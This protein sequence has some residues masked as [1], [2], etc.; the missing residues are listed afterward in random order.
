MAKLENLAEAVGKEEWKKA[1]QD[2]TKFV[3]WVKTTF[4]DIESYL[5]FIDAI[6]GTIEKNVETYPPE[7]LENH[8]EILRRLLVA[9]RSRTRAFV[10]GRKALEN[11][12]RM[13]TAKAS[14]DENIQMLESHQPEAALLSEPR[15]IPFSSGI[16]D[17]LFDRAE[18]LDAPFQVVKN[19]AQELKRI[20]DGWDVLLLVIDN[21]PP[22]V[23]QARNFLDL[24]D[25]HAEVLGQTRNNLTFDWISGIYPTITNSDE[26][27]KHLVATLQ[28][29]IRRAEAV[30]TAGEVAGFEANHQIDIAKI[31]N[32][33][34]NT[35]QDPVSHFGNLDNVRATLP[36]VMMGL[37]R[38]VEN[39]ASNLPDSQTTQ[40]QLQPIIDQGE[41]HI[42][43]LQTRAAE[44]FAYATD[45]TAPNFDTDRDRGGSTRYPVSQ[46]VTLYRV[47][48]NQNATV[49]QL[50]TAW[51][52]VY[53]GT[54]LIVAVQPE[55]PGL[56]T[57]DIFR[58]WEGFAEY[59]ASL[60]QAVQEKKQAV[61]N[62]EYQQ[63]V[64]L[65]LDL[66]FYILNQ[67]DATNLTNRITGERVYVT[68]LRAMRKNLDDMYSK[69]EE[70][71]RN[72][73]LAIQSSDSEKYQNAR[74]R[75]KELIDVAAQ[76]QFLT[77]QELFDLLR[78]LKVDF[79]DFSG[80]R[81]MGADPEKV[82]AADEFNKRFTFRRY[83]SKEDY[84]KGEMYWIRMVISIA[85]D[86]LQ[87]EGGAAVSDMDQLSEI[88]DS[89]LFDRN[90]LIN[91][92]TGHPEYGHRMKN[93]L[94]ALKK[95]VAV[96]GAQTHIVVAGESLSVS[97]LVSGLTYEELCDKSVSEGGRYKLSR[98]IDEL[99]RSRPDLFRL[100]AEARE[101]AENL[102]LMFSVL[103][104]SFSQLMLTTKTRIV[105]TTQKTAPVGFYEHILG[106]LMHAR[107]RYDSGNKYWAMIYLALYKKLP[108]SVSL[109]LNP[110]FNHLLAWDDPVGRPQILQERVSKLNHLRDEILGWI[111]CF[112]PREWMEQFAVD[113]PRFTEAAFFPY[114]DT[115]LHK[116]EGEFTVLADMIY[117]HDNKP[118]VQIQ[119][120]AEG[121]ET[122]FLDLTQTPPAEVA[123]RRADGQFDYWDGSTWQVGANTGV[124]EKNVPWK[125][126][127]GSGQ[128]VPILKT[129][130]LL[131]FN[132]YFNVAFPAW[133]EIFDAFASQ[134]PTKITAEEIISSGGEG[135]KKGLIPEYTATW[136]KAKQWLGNHMN[137]E[138][139]ALFF[140]DHVFKLLAAED[141]HDLDRLELIRQ[142]ITHLL[143]SLDGGAAR[144]EK[145]ILI[146][147]YRLINTDEDGA[148]Y[149][150]RIDDYPGIRRAAE[151][152][153]NDDLPIRTKLVLP[154]KRIP[155][156]DDAYRY[157]SV[158]ARAIR[159]TN[160]R[161][162]KRKAHLEHV[163][164]AELAPRSD[165]SLP[166]YA[167]FRGEPKN[168]TSEQL[169]GFDSRFKNDH[170][171]HK[172]HWFQEIWI[173]ALPSRW[174]VNEK[175]DL[176]LGFGFDDR[177][178]K[179]S[180]GSGS[181]K[182]ESGEK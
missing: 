98:A 181:A 127:L 120:N 64:E 123:K 70:E 9:H 110:E 78:R 151:K 52:A 11:E 31:R 51:G 128:R 21:A 17:Q 173:D 30:V 130:A 116:R 114:H 141:S 18:A 81:S 140:T 36:T 105:N 135:S 14:I 176:Q 84:L 72:K 74:K 86:K 121:V 143:G 5:E 28:I 3:E 25:V 179:Q 109:P 108:T 71:L 164:R 47:I 146:V 104:I 169:G 111:D 147:I 88:L 44:Y 134:Y 100:P 131:D 101:L 35:Y 136:G 137:T 138:V 75:I 160:K 132:Q 46:F 117:D 15:P 154:K 162:A 53:D 158:E 26:L 45:I 92:T 85:V 1:P 39:L 102:Y 6:C 125:V 69:A 178:G 89:H 41:Q 103:E 83:K 97:S 63:E 33:D 142:I 150:L 2:R 166:K 153:A 10:N 57:P 22:P 80:A 87:A 99:M 24:V 149:G 152:F 161:R 49:A 82:T 129:A 42:A 29:W 60:Q 174:V 19:R 167:E 7:E 172:L 12:G 106:H 23:S 115:L 159:G 27:K 113:L 95:I 107:F 54:N 144:F 61:S 155:I 38:A 175:K 40:E 182:V 76:P 112:Y 145:G 170:H 148:F 8:I 20:R 171:N 43:F 50:N 156:R 79:S 16:P 65:F 68:Q 94:E 48:Q 91:I 58:G 96:K 180:A 139:V 118:V 93:V 73:S 56:F 157:I 168:A 177:F 66:A 37:H 67:V 165:T 90:R 32:F 4:T 62:A 119:T 77:D 133:R 124:T 13:K 59:I 163:W 55:V 122:G 126:T 34:Q